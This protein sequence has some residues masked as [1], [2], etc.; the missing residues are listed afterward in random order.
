LRNET[1]QKMIN[2]TYDWAVADIRTRPDFC[3]S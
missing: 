1:Q 2:P 3:D